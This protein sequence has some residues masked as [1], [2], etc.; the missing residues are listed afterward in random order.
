[1]NLLVDIGNTRIKWACSNGKTLSG[2]NSVFYASDTISELLA[3]NWQVL[4]KPERVHIASVADF[5][6]TRK[7]RE[8]ISG[9]WS[10]AS[11]VAVTERERGGLKNAYFDV[12]SMGVD[13]WLVMLAAWRKFRA[14]LCVI[15]YGTAVTVDAVLEDGRHIGGFILPG[16]AMTTAALIR[17]THKIHAGDEP[18]PE[19]EFG[20]STSECISNGFVFALA[21]LLD[22]CIKKINAGK[23]TAPLLVI[24]GGAAEQVLPFLPGKYCHEPHL[25]LEGLN[26]VSQSLH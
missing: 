10:L 15:D 20:C 4:S 23:N 18:A 7:V 21:G 13:R 5:S 12:T 14:P 2:H 3:R 11:H 22:Q 25:V 19:L 24:T 9:S 17:D 6:T 16:L 26:L 8:F 1:M